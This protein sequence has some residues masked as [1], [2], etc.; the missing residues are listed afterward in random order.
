MKYTLFFI[1]LLVIFNSCCHGFINVDENEIIE[2]F[3]DFEIPSVSGTWGDVEYTFDGIKAVDF[4]MDDFDISTGGDD[5]TMTVSV[6]G[7]SGKMRTSYS[8]AYKK[9]F[10]SFKYDGV[11]EASFD[12]GDIQFT[13]GL[14]DKY[15]LEME[16]CESAFDDLDITFSGD[17]GLDWILNQIADVVEWLA[18]DLIND[19]ICPGLEKLVDAGSEDLMKSLIANIKEDMEKEKAKEDN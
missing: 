15:E 13:V 16:E 10:F 1:S 19:Q 17:G 6:R 3:E 18:V 11:I 8:V 5:E 9:W 4:D 12:G 7:A 2:F 14:K